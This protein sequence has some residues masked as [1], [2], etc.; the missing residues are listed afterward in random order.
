[1]YIMKS[2]ITLVLVLFFAVMAMAQTQKNH[3]KVYT[4]QMDIVLVVSLPISLDME[5]VGFTKK[6]SVARLYR[7]QNSRIKKALSFKTKKDRPKLA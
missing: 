4:T 1:M 2:I 5:K 3:D 7:Y 6:N